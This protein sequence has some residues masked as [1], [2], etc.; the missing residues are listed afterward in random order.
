MYNYPLTSWSIHAGSTNYAGF[1]EEAIESWFGVSHSMAQQYFLE[2]TVICA[3]AMHISKA[4]DGFHKIIE[5]LRRVPG[6]V[7]VEEQIAKID[8]SRRNLGVG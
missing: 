1:D 6:A 4:V 7:L 2:A 5:E 3:N 8:Q